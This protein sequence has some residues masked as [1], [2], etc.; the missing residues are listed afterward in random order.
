LWG[1][2]LVGGGFDRDRARARE[3][4]KG[5]EKWNPERLY[6]QWLGLFNAFAT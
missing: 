2:F 5:K 6:K 1:G 4:V 3:M